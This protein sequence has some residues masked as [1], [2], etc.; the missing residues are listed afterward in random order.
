MY[1]HLLLKDAN[2][3]SD[4]QNPCKA[5]RDSYPKAA[6]ARRKVEVGETPEACRPTD[7]TYTV[8]TIGDTQSEKSGTGETIVKEM[9]HGLYAATFTPPTHTRLK[10]EIKEHTTQSSPLSITISSKI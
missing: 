10:R 4:T 3:T 7:L 8:K 5:K 2:L 9:H 6:I 1:S